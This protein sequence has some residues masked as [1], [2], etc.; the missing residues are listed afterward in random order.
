MDDDDGRQLGAALRLHEIALEAGDAGNLDRLGDDARVALRHGLRLGVVVLQDRQQRGRCGGAAGQRREPVEE[1]AAV[2]AAVGEVV[3]EIDDALIHGC[4]P[5]ADFVPRIAHLMRS[6][7]ARRSIPVEGGFLHSLVTRHFGARVGIEPGEDE[8][9][10]ERDD[11]GDEPE[12]RREIGGRPIAPPPPAGGRLEREGAERDPDAE[13]KLLRHAGQARGIA[14]V[15]V[16]DVGIGDGVEAGE[17][18]RAEAA[19]DEE[20][21]HDQPMRRRRREEAVGREEG[22][23][24]EGV[25]RQEHGGSRISSRTL[26]GERFREHRANRRDEGERAGLQRDSG[27]SRSE[28]SAAAGTESRRCRCGTGSRRARWSRKVGIFRRLELDHRMRASA[29]RAG[30]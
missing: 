28:A 30:R 9:P 21:R 27:R 15:A 12:R 23:A 2:H 22:R 29:A 11:R 13:R 3:V 25:D 6:V 1:G 7:P 16:R 18:Q 14:H 10:R 17:L 20:D 19:A 24:D 4:P 5:V 26:L 8:P